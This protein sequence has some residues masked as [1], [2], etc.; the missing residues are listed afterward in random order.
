[1][2]ATGPRLSLGTTAFI[3]VPLLATHWTFAAA[4]T[5]LGISFLRDGGLR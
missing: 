4:R 5:A 3:D 1:V 2:I